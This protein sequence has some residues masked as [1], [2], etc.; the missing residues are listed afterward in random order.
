MKTP[1]I[2]GPHGQAWKFDM[3][4]IAKKRNKPHA[5]LADWCIKASWAHPFWHSYSLSLIHLRPVSGLPVPIIHLP[6]ATHEMFL[7]ALDPTWEM[8]LDERPP[9]LNPVN[10][11]A[12][13][14]ERDDKS[15]IKRIEQSVIEI[16]HGEL[17]PDTDFMQHWIHRY[18]ASNVKGD[19]A[20]AGETIVKIEHKDGSTTELVIDPASL[21]K[22]PKP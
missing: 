14:I 15:A 4:K 20:K 13:F 5:G 18:G 2:E 11:V 16:V 3:E 1:D 22:K 17:S 12:Q 10:F 21:D 7:F 6:G 9:I 19:P 8:K